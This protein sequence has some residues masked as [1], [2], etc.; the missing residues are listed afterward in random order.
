MCGVSL[1]LNMRQRGRARASER[2]SKTERRE[3]E[4]NEREIREKMERDEK[5]RTV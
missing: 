5:E 4:R 3:R 2:V 1:G